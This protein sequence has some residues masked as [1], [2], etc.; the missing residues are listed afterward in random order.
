MEEST[1]EKLLPR[2]TNGLQVSKVRNI[3]KNYL[4]CDFSSVSFKKNPKTTFGL[5]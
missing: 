2:K 4:E 1:G 3:S 5:T